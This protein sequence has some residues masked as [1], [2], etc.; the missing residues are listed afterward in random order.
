MVATAMIVPVVTITM[1]VMQPVRNVT[2][3]A[4][5]HAGQ[6]ARNVALQHINNSHPC[7]DANALH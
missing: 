1:V 7:A 5:N 3:S 4:F 2:R 6:H